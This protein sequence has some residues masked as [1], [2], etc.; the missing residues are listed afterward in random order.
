MKVGILT[1]YDSNNFGSYLQAYALKKVIEEM[2][3]SV[4]FI[5]FR[6]EKEVKK[7]YY[8]SRK[9]LLH[10]LK[11]YSFNTKKYNLFLED[12][13]N[14]EEISIKDVKKDT[15][16]IVIIGSDECWNVKTP[17]F[18]N[19]CFYGIDIPTEKKV[20]FAISCGKAVTEDFKDFP[21]LVEGI[22][23]LNKIFVRDERTQKNVKELIGKDAE[24]VCDPTFLIDVKEFDKE[25]DVNI[26]KE[27]LLVYSYNFTEKQ[28]EYIKKF[29]KEQNLLIVSA[30]FK[31]SFCDKCINCSPLEFCKL[32]QNSK[33]VI[34]TTFHGTIFSILNKKQF[35]SIP[36]GQKVVDVLNKT[37]LIKCE[38]KENEE[39]YEEFK[40]KLLEEIN[41]DIS[42]KNILEWR[43]KSL[44][45]L[46][47]LL[48]E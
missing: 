15:F 21:D 40:N 35:I 46:E 47:K 38:F 12:R 34:T 32:I 13:K 8:P 17:T 11:S 7:I 20:A 27:Y 14:F 44:S 19:K 39:E 33:Y 43:N 3:H 37:G 31:H 26:N 29:A 25:Y 28:K 2:G 36:S 30:C 4:K 10:Y 48:K 41:F 18:R 1:V 16:D 6:T 9:N 22:Q 5:K 23:N 45:I 42:Q 24:M